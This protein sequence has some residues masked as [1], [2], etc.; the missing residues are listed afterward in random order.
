MKRLK[1][2]DKDGCAACLTCNMACS[3]GYYKK[4]SQDLSCI[5][6]TEKDG[7]PKV[8]VCTQCGKCAE[9]CEYGAITKNKNGVYTI[10]KKSCKNCFKCVDACPFHVMVKSSN[11]APPSKC[12]ACTLCSKSCPLGIIAI[13][14]KEGKAPV[15]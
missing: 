8:V 6:I 15:A 2:V 9:A 3:E 10:N 13:E 1:V 7:K 12:I 4:F 5:K 14:E 11:D